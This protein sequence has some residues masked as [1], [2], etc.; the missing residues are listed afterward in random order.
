MSPRARRGPAPAL[1]A[2]ALACVVFL[3]APR[4]AR[5]WVDVNVEGDDVRLTI[6]PTGQVRVEHRIT[7]KIAG[8]PLR[9]IDLRGV[10]RDATPETDGYVVPQREAQSSS[11][12]SAIPIA[13]ELMPP[14]NKAED[15]GSPPLA[16]MKIRFQNDRGLGRGVYVILVRYTSSLANRVTLDGAM[17]RV[18]WRGPIWDDGLDS[19]RVTFD[20]PAAPNEPRLDEGAPGF[21]DVAPTAVGSAPAPITLATVKRSVTRDAIELMRPY[22]PKGERITWAVRADARALRG[23][24]PDTSRAAPTFV[25]EDGLAAPAR[26]A[27]VLACAFAIFAAFAL[28]VARKSIDVARSAG[29]A[30]ATA[31]P[32]VRLPMILRALLAGMSL[33]AG[34]A[35]ELVLHRATLGALLVLAAT[36]FASHLPASWNAGARLRGPGRWLPVAEAEAFRDPPRA[37]GGHLDASTLNGRIVFLLVLAAFAGGIYLLS[38]ISA[39]Q[40]QIVAFD[41]TAL[42]AV[43]GT[44]LR[45]SL[46]P[47]P[48]S[49]PASFLRKVAKLVK[50]EQRKDLPRI[51]GRI[52]VSEG[53]AM[54]DE[55]RLAVL[56]RAAITGFVT[57]EIGVV[58][59]AGS[60]GSI[61][62]P[63]VLL[64]VTDGSECDKALQPLSRHGRSMRGRKAGERVYAFSPRLPTARMTAGLVTRLAR[65]VAVVA[66]ATDAMPKSKIA[67]RRAA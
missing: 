53:S 49:A 37:P 25:N 40:S 36:L 30:G 10:D 54:P 44:G 41:F 8:G 26:R 46:P 56:P 13:A 6:A 32:L 35:V 34:L 47:D 45:S 60:G 20:F 2:L 62:L 11:L 19:A 24:L 14:G 22:A 23:A 59:I 21:G 42:L 7:L 43:F 57:I 5:A 12:A 63:E 67:P 55:L 39:Y 52:R 28:L 38:D 16:V 61:A 9:A 33:V 15:D 29:S 51:V 27:L 58:H 18:S 3:C 4:S 50:R 17:A 65:A 66:A 31:R 64:R 1:F 48:G